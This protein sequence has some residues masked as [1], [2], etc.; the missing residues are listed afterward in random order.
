MEN[1]CTQPTGLQFSTFDILQYET[2]SGTWSISVMQQQESCYNGMV[3]LL[4]ETERGKVPLREMD[5]R[6]ICSDVCMENCG[7]NDGN[8]GVE[9]NQT[10]NWA[11]VLDFKGRNYHI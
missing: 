11:P 8:I 3:K 5:S 4:R 2:D 7:G 10:L 9:N 1:I 6:E